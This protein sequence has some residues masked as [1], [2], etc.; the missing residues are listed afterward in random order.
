MG[1]EMAP[2]IYEDCSKEE[3]LKHFE[4][5]VSAIES[6]GVKLSPEA[7]RGID[8]IIEAVVVDFA[9][10][11]LPALRRYLKRSGIESAAA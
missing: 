5:I 4:E 8:E 11:D 3:L 6:R 1:Q 10:N 7:R 2:K 9:R